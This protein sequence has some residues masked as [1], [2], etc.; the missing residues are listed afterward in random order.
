M[1]T[2]RIELLDIYGRV[3][4]YPRNQSA[5]LIAR[6]AGTKTLTKSALSNTLALGCTVQIVDRFGN[7][8]RSYDPG[9]IESLPAIA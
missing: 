1:I 9:R 7:V 4:A 3:V 5:E 2:I 6:I 8:S